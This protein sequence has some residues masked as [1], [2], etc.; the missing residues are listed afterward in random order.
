MEGESSEGSFEER[1]YFET[2]LAGFIPEDGFLQVF[3]D[4]DTL[5]QISTEIHSLNIHLTTPDHKVQIPEE[6][7]DQFQQISYSE[8][9]DDISDT[10]SILSSEPEQNLPLES[11]PILNSEPEVTEPNQLF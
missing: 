9:K 2:D 5:S 8:S 4:L 6:G 3:Q 7:Q 1:D 11:D 10:G